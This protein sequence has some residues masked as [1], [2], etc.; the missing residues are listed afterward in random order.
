MN[1]I[2]NLG[3]ELYS[4]LI[5]DCEEEELLIIA[6]GIL[7]YLPFDVLKKGERYLIDDFVLRHATSLAF[8][9]EVEADNEIRSS[10]LISPSYNQY[11][12]SDQQLA[13]R[14]EAYNLDGA[15]AETDAIAEIIPARKLSRSKASK[16]EFMKVASQYDLLHLSMHSF[17]NDEDPELSSLVFYDGEEEN[18]LFIGELYGM[19]LDAKLAV[20]S[21]CNTGVGI[22]K[23][24]EGMVSVNHAFTYA[25]VPAVVSSLWSA[26]DKATKDIMTTFYKELKA[27]ETKAQ[28]LRR[29][30]LKYR[31]N[32]EVEALA[33]PFFWG[34]FV[35]HG[36]NEALDFVQWSL[37]TKI[38]L[39]IFSLLVLL[40]LGYFFRRFQ[41]PKRLL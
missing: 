27:G 5:P 26:P 28:A 33:H 40:I 22:E 4:I 30:K 10:L 16:A 31:D 39:S 3:N 20:L 29:A 14:G 23:T 12:L 6:D 1:R 13:V 35:L 38:S 7:N 17:M 24:G 37:T 21:A 8:L 36:S 15:L 19:N 41:R 9:A 34:G 2:T 25:G 11:T 32:Q 18:E